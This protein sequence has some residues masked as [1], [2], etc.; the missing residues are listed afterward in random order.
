MWWRWWWWYGGGCGVGCGPV[1]G[2]GVGDGSGGFGGAVMVVEVVVK[3]FVK[4]AV[5][6]VLGALY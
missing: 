2:C 5:V 3:A 1:G 4:L 6:I